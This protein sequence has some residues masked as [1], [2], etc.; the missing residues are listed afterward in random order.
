MRYNLVK[1]RGHVF[2]G[3]W[4]YVYMESMEG[5]NKRDIYCN[6]NS[7]TTK[8]QQ[9]NTS[10]E[11][12]P[13]SMSLSPLLSCWLRLSKRLPS[14][15]TLQVIAIFHG[16]ALK[17]ETESIFL[18]T[19][20]MGPKGPWAGSYLKASSLRTSFHG[21]RW[22]HASFQRRKANNNLNQL[23]HLR[24]IKTIMTWLPQGY[25]SCTHNLVVA[26]RSLSGLNFHSKNIEK[27][28]EILPD[29]KRIANFLGLVKSWIMK[30]NL[31]L[32]LF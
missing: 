22:H 4:R 5:E 8:K 15:K 17:E 13:V 19:L 12:S 20:C 16:V 1:K 26:N 6:Y 27:E 29:I 3:V 2:E 25:S 24:N 18:K 11:G 9:K 10:H 31:Q 14:P 30:E 7:K 32:P 28:K 23:C 21:K